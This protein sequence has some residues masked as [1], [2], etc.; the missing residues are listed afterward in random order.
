MKIAGVSMTYNDGYK[1]KE[2]VSHYQTYK[3]QLE[4]FVIVDNGSKKEYKDQLKA[5]FPDATIIERDTNGGCTAAYNDGIRYVLQN[6][7]V[8]SIAIIGNDLKLTENCLC[9]M[10]EYLFSD[11][12]MGMVSSAILNINS[13]IVDNYGHTVNGFIVKNCEKG[14]NINDV[15]PKRKETELISGGFNIAKKEFY[16]RAGL[17]DEN[18]FMYCDEL[19]TT[20]KA[21]KAGFKLG[22]IADEYAW[23][24]H[25]NPP[26]AVG[27]RHPESRYMISR[28]RVYLSQKYMGRI[29]AFS[30][31]VYTGI[32]APLKM[33]WVGFTRHDKSLFIDAQYGFL[34]ALYGLSGNMKENKYSFPIKERKN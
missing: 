22:V 15:V 20:F 24:W 33:I 16:E 18:L 14:K 32:M 13:M 26:G 17:Q 3:D 8:D 1:L 4:C 25:I 29:K 31:F 5:A 28:N 10:H 30:C 7:N 27:I 2:W 12:Q 23:H 9:A 19:D 34:G 11:S 21:K 6:E